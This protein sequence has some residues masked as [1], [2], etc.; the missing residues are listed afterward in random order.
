MGYTTEFTGKIAITPPLPLEVVEKVNSFCEERHEDGYKIL[1]SIWCDWR[2]SDD[3]SSIAWNGNE[4]SYEM[5]EWLS[6]LIGKFMKGHTLNGK[7]LA[8]GESGDDTWTLA[9][10]DSKVSVQQLDLVDSLGITR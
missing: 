3:G 2:V 10:K 9:C 4:K 8:R 6:F 1:P 7:L 5:P